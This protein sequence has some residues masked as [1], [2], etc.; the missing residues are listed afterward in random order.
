MKEREDFEGFTDVYEGSFTRTES[1]EF[2][3][4]EEKC[5]RECEWEDF[6]CNKQEPENSFSFVEDEAGYFDS[7]APRFQENRGIKKRTMIQVLCLEWREAQI[8][9]LMQEWEDLCKTKIQFSSDSSDNTKKQEMTESVLTPVLSQ[10]YRELQME[11]MQVPDV[12]KF[13][14]IC[15]T[16]E[17]GSGKSEEKNTKRDFPVTP[18]KIDSGKTQR[19]TGNSLIPI[20]NPEWRK[21]QFRNLKEK[22]SE[23]CRQW[24]SFTPAISPEWK[25]KNLMQLK[26]EKDFSISGITVAPKKWITRQEEEI[27]NSAVSVTPKEGVGGEDFVVKA[28]KR[29]ENLKKEDKLTAHPTSRISTLTTTSADLLKTRR[30]LT[31][32]LLI[33]AEIGLVLSWLGVQTVLLNIGI[34]YDMISGCMLHFFCQSLRITPIHDI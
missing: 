29:G 15:K 25:N 9:A 3:Y 31:H 1:E 30:R 7:F 18:K 28:T 21:N 4:Y 17:K 26:K 20:L 11:I 23:K 33:D 5:F 16:E 24:C 32:S 2:A 34:K 12:E 22:T 14:N 27:K 13:I 6:D 10:E 19:S 8:N